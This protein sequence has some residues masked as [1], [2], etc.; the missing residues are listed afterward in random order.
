[1]GE[2]ERG[3]GFGGEGNYVQPYWAPTVALMPWSEIW[4]CRE[5]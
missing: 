4:Y 2:G 5:G 3:R 1:M